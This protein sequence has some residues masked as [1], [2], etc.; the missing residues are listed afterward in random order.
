MTVELQPKISPQELRKQL[1]AIETAYLKVQQENDDLKHEVKHLKNEVA[2]LRQQLYGT[3]SEKI[4]FA[5][6]S[7]VQADEPV[8]D[9]QVFDEA[10]ITDVVLEENNE[11][12][13]AAAVEK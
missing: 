1:M 10:S 12:E 9:Q 3:K 8:G 13:I 11:A 5:K 6:T 7:S 2:L 4:K